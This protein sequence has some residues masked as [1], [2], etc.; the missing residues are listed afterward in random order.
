MISNIHDYAQ[1]FTIATFNQSKK[2]FE[3]GS[4]KLTQLKDLLPTS[5]R[6]KECVKNI[7]YGSQKHFGQF[8]QTS[9]KMISSSTNY[10][11]TAPTSQKA[12][13]ISAAALTVIFFGYLSKNDPIIINPVSNKTNVSSF[14]LPTDIKLEDANFTNSTLTNKTTIFNSQTAHTA[15]K[16]LVKPPST[17]RNEVE[18][19]SKHGFCRMV[20]DKLTFTFKNITYEIACRNKQS[21]LNICKVFK[22]QTTSATYQDAGNI[23]FE[24]FTIAML[25]VIK[26]LNTKAACE[27]IELILASKLEFTFN[28]RTQKITPEELILASN[29]PK[30]VAFI[31]MVQDVCYN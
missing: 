5:D 14:T 15:F 11:Q 28:G 20:P 31:K 29:D 23:Y 30:Y 24:D 21:V 7:V 10:I 9:S 12:V 16:H 17:E 8:V 27:K 6:T 13:I 3:Y 19:F 1:N 2:I 4:T 22:D 26:N 18:P 25:M